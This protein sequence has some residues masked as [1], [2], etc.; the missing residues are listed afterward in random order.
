MTPALARR[1]LTCSEGSWQRCPPPWRCMGAV[2]A[3]RAPGPGE[4]VGLGWRAHRRQKCLPG[5]RLHQPQHRRPCPQWVPESPGMLYAPLP[6]RSLC[7]LGTAPAP[8]QGPSTLRGSS[9]R[10]MTSLAHPCSRASASSPVSGSWQGPLPVE[11][12]VSGDPWE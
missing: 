1:P 10:D 5:T 2:R 6:S 8:G 12:Q 9:P 3:C 4:L 11:L 7:V